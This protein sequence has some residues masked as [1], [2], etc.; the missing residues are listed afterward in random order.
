[1]GDLYD[2]IWNLLIVRKCID[3]SHVTGKTLEETVCLSSLVDK[4]I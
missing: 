1:M 4:T 2:Y 3:T